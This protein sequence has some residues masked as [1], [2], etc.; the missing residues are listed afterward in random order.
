MICTRI[1]FKSRIVLPAARCL[2]TQQREPP[3]QPIQPL[4]TG[5]LAGDDDFSAKILA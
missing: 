4:S 5:D 2:T 1:V 3:I